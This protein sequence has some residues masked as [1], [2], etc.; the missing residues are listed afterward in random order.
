MI[1]QEI[2]I[3]F[4]DKNKKEEAEQLQQVFMRTDF[5]L[6]PTRAECAG[7]VFS[8]AS[9]WGIPS[10]TTDTGGV[11]TYVK[12]G[13]NGYALPMQ[14]KAESYADLICKLYKEKTCLEELKQSS[15]DFYDHHLSWEHWGEQFRQIARGLVNQYSLSAEDK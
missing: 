7:I 2:K 12:D 9:A 13:I 1:F 6:L 5:L 14:A 11:T 8:E 3:P 15:R 10:I 4:L